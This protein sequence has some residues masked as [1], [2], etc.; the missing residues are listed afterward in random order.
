MKI[1]ALI[2]AV[3][4][5]A[6]TAFAQAPND[7]AKAPADTAKPTASA[8]G[9]TVH[10]ASK[11]K[12]KKVSKKKSS[13]HAMGAGPAMV[14]TDLNASERQSRM[15]QAYANWQARGTR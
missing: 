15:D 12:H 6:G 10:K 14:S 8:D 5:L 7:S 3:A 1:Q 4:L 13:T 9:K 11:K 2:A